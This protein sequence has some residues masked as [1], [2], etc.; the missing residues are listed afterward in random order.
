MSISNL[1]AMTGVSFAAVVRSGSVMVEGETVP[2][3]G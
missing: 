2:Y 3:K 1:D